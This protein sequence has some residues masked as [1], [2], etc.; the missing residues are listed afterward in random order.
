M[1]DR[2]RGAGSEWEV[3]PASTML[4]PARRPGQGGWAGG[5]LLLSQGVSVGGIIFP[6]CLAV[7]SKLSKSLLLESEKKQYG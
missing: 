7:L 6:V 2:G 4:V 1:L 3:N 5:G